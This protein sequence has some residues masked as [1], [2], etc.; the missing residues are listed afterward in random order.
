MKSRGPGFAPHL[1]L[2]TSFEKESHLKL[3]KDFIKL[4]CDF[5]EFLTLKLK[6]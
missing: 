5:A 6:V 1:P 4:K 3:G 2:A